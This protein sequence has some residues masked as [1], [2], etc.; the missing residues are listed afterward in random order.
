[1]LGTVR[2]LESHASFENDR[3]DRGFINRTT[4]DPETSE[5]ARDPEG[6]F[7]AANFWL[8]ENY[9]LQGRMT[10]ARALFERL[11]GVANDVGLLAEE[12]DPR[13]G[14]LTGNFP[15][16]FSHAALINAAQHFR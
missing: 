12:Y 2:A 10:E 14:R 6:S 7:L 11:L 15:Q 1:V 13:T 16:T 3:S 4:N 9:A 5:D 8:V